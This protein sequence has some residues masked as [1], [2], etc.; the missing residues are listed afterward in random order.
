M[1]KFWFVY[2]AKAIIIFSGGFGTLDELFELMTLV[3]TKKLIKSMPIVL[4]GEEFWHSVLNF[5]ALVEHGTIDANDLG[6]FLETD[7]VDE[8]FKFI[9]CE[10]EENALSR[11]GTCL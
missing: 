8:A 4:F 5:D 1:R 6:L 2:L 7:S 3:Q 10:L 9:T 11:P